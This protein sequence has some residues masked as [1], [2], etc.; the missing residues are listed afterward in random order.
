M[1]GSRVRLQPRDDR[2]LKALRV[3]GIVDREGAS[4]V[5]GFRSTTRVNARLLKLTRAG[6]LG[7]VFL[8]GPGFSKR[9]YY[10]LPA[11]RTIRRMAENQERR[12]FGTA[13]GLLHQ[14]LLSEVLVQS[15]KDARGLSTDWRRFSE[16]LSRQVQLIPDAYGEICGTAA[17]IEADRGTETRKVWDRK[18]ELYLELA[19]SGQFGALFHQPRFRVLVITEEPNRARFLSA[20]VG[21]RTSHLFWF[22]DIDT[23]KHEGFFQPIWLRPGG[24]EKVSFVGGTSCATVDNA[25]ASSQETRSSV[26]SAGEASTGASVA[27]DT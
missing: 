13:P 11:D 21:T 9:A 24:R 26:I 10:F 7:R 25:D 2:L 20:H 8:D 5:A 6:L 16:P 19:R 18:V 22:S 15:R 17:F 12:R 3:I 23:I 14:L 27:Q 1:G 4:L